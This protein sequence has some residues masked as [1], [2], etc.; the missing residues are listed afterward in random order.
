MK[1]EPIP[2]VVRVFSGNV[3]VGLAIVDIEQFY[4]HA[5]KKID[6][7]QERRLWCLKNPRPNT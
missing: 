1:S 3:E 2:G 4:Q 7:D 6:L 5:D